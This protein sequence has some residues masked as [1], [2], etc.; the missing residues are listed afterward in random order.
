MDTVVC[1]GDIYGSGNGVAECCS[2]LQRKQIPTVRGNHD[3][4]LIEAVEGD[5]NLRQSV[6]L[7]VVQF[8]SGLPI[9]LKINTVAG[10]G[11]VCHGIGTNDLAHLPRTFPRSLVRR[12][13][14]VGLIPPQCTL[15]IHGH[16]HLQRQQTCEGVLFVAVG[17]LRAH[18]V[19]GCIII[20]TKTGLVLPVAY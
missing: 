11:L 4:W 2:L 14:R 18:P 10:E 13:F 12:S 1:V 6:G 20:D 17:A 15:V 8:L 9:T 7:E 5:E 16:S 3:R 19:G